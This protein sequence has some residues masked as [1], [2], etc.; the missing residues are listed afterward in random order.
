MDGSDM[1]KKLFSRGLVQGEETASGLFAA[2]VWF[3]T[4]GAKYIQYLNNHLF[5]A[6]QH[7]AKGQSKFT[8]NGLLH[9]LGMHAHHQPASAI[10]LQ[11]YEHAPVAH[12]NLGGIK[13][14]ANSTVSQ[15]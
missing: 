3:K 12:F 15:F 1:F 5:F 13:R 4:K 2:E 6:D 9:L 10:H 11:N 8:V 14:T 7:P